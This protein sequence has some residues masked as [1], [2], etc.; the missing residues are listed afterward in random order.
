ME[1]DLLLDVV[2][3]R[4]FQDSMNVKNAVLRDLRMGI[5]MGEVVITFKIMPEDSDVDLGKLKEE[6]EKIIKI[7]DYKIE[8]LAFGL[9]VLKVLIVS[10][11]SGT[12][13]IEKILKSVKGVGEVEVESSTLL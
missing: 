9:K 2:G 5:K 1:K 4:D 10:E 12:E 7:Q 6:I 11:D 8:P 13:E 3:A